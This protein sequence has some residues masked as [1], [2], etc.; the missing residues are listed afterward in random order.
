MTKKL[1]ITIKHISPRYRIGE[2]I[3]LL[4]S[5]GKKTGRAV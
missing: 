2:L 5:A 3:G 1:D 4:F